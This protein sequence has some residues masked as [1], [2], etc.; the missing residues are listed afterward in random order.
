MNKK[1]KD[2]AIIGAGVIGLLLAKQLANNGID[3]EVFDS[4]KDVAENA[5]KASGIL[6]ISGLA[7]LDVNYKPAIINALNGARIYTEKAELSISA[8]DYKAY[9]L[10]RR[11]LAEVCAKE[12]SKAGAVLK[13]GSRLTKLEIEK[14]KNE[15][16]VI[17]GAD[18]AVSTVASTFNFPSIKDYILTYKAEFKNAHIDDDKK[19]EIYFKKNITKRFFGWI[20]PYSKTDL[21]VGI[22][23]S[24]KEYRN[25]F[26]AFSMFINDDMIKK[27]LKG[28]QMIKGYASIIPI[29]Y[30]SITVKDNVLL[31]GD[32]AGQVKATTGGGIIFGS[33]CANVAAQSIIKYI[34][35]NVSLS[36][37]EKGWR[38]RYIKDLRM[39]RFI[40]SL[41]SNMD[42]NSL[43]TLIK[44]SKVFG[45]EKFLS[46]YGDMDKPSLIIKRF[47][48]RS[49]N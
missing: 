23:I 48:L 9:I 7:D 44:I 45:I 41:Y 32:A 25:S 34:R 4:K 18:G 42:E 31:V 19:V 46:E 15:Y 24:E 36:N 13:L 12:A 17:V 5:G 16:K 8:K 10:D 3:V 28:A 22:G 30:R 11:K 40:H 33:L 14:M 20:A 38:K 39:H 26:N 35:N 47:F 6:S 29:K 1:N 43:S 21:E 37:Y 49:K 27:K 2:V